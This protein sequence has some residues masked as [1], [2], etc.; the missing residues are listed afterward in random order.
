MI[1]IRHVILLL[2]L[3]LPLAGQAALEIR[4]TQGVE[5][6]LPIAI[7][8]FGWQGEAQVPEDLAAIIGANLHRSGR[9]APVE[10]QA[11]PQ[12]P[13][14]ADELDFP[15]WR[16]QGSNYVVIGRLQPTGA[17]RFSVQFQLFD[18]AGGRQLTGYSIPVE[19]AD[20]RRAAHMISDI[21]YERLTGERGAFDTR[22][23]YVSV[24]G[25]GSER[26]FALQVADADGHHPRTIF[27]S[28][29][30]IM[31]PAWGPDG[32]RIAYVSFENGRSE[33]FVQ[34]VDGGD[35]TR[36]AA[37]EGINSAP[38][39]SPDGRRLALTLSRD[40]APDI[41]VMNLSDRSVTR[42]TQSRS[43]DTEPVWMPDGRS[44]I[45][46][47]D[48]AGQPQLYEVAVTGGQPRRLS[49]EG[50]YNGGASISP[51]GRRVA[52][53]HGVGGGF[54][55]ALLDRQTRQFRVLTDGR[56]DEAPSFA[57][58][59]SMIIYATS[60]RGRGILAAVSVDGRVHQRL[61]LQEGEV[62]EPAWSP[63]R[64]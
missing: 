9:F 7:V 23:A 57:P 18:V 40:G 61:V 52:M 1:Q 63:F 26:R 6:A 43:I 33:V 5:G 28:A 64:D 62:R 48:R 50:R 8:P 41:Y 11:M 46:T 19:R 29:Q 44:L 37:F 25:Q 32:R 3:C 10:R 17:D 53:V 20:L 36:L 60:E 39:W 31:S 21:V 14:R 51:D 35:R 34:N 27:R 15:A 49:F 16:G 24:T 45:F 12:R 2:L 22:V 30:P 59:G 47:S 55:I 4:I 58:N 56:A 38:A 13:T 42:V 54:R